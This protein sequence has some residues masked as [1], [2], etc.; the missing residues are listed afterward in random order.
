MYEIAKHAHGAPV[1]RWGP[2]Q[3]CRD[4]PQHKWL[5]VG[6]ERSK[7]KAIALAE[8]QPVHAVVV[9]A[10]TS[11]KV[12]DNGKQPADLG[13]NAVRDEFKPRR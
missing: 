13:E 1:V 8:A 10:Y 6:K 9:V 12:F 3:G 4:F 5:T 11:T 2:M 7:A